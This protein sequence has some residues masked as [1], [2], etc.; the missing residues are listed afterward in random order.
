MGN[1][2]QWLLKAWCHLL[3][4]ARSVTRQQGASD[5][6]NPVLMGSIAGDNFCETSSKTKHLAVPGAKLYLIPWVTIFFSYFPKKK[7]LC[8]F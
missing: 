5:Y 2:T 4:T 8:L 1:S 6:I 7:F 3:F